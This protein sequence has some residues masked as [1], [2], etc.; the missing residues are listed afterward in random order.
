MPQIAQ[1]AATYASQ[2]FWMLIIFGA[3]YVGIGK[4]MLPKIEATVDQ[5]DRKISGDLAAAER[6]RAEADATEEAYRTR[7]D[8]ARAGA[9]KTAADAKAAA[10]LDSEAKVKA[11]DAVLAE[12]GA[13]AEARLSA[14]RGNALASIETVA[15]E[16]AQ[17]IV[18]RLA[19]IPV[20]SAEAAHAVKDALSAQ[21]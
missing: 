5:R 7:M 17:D 14:A 8:A 16:A 20:S 6:A 11:A 18:A 13:A 19:G 9:Q 15:A 10:L 12:Q 4:L 21:R 3:I 2:I 1:L